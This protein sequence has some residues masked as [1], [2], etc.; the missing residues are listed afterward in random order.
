MSLSD[1]DIAFATDLFSDLPNLTKRKMFG[2][3][4]L[5]SDGIVFALMASDAQIYLKTKTPDTLYGR[6]AEQFHNM[7]YWSLPDDLLD[8]PQAASNRAEACIAS[9]A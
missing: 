5:Y 6:P 4:C 1:A 9:L 8:D 7:P 2:G 3:M